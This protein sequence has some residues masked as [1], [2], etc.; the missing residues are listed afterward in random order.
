[1]EKWYKYIV[2]NLCRILICQKI[3]RLGDAA[4]DADCLTPLRVLK[5]TTVSVKNGFW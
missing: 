1:M 4:F 5:I 2:P 3:H